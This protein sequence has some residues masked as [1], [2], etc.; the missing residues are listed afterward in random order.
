MKV[1]TFDASSVPARPRAVQPESRRPVSGEGVAKLAHRKYLVESQKRALHATIHGS[2]A[3]LKAIADELGMEYSSLANFALASRTDQLPFTQLPMVLEAAD[4]LTLLR[5]YA[6]LQGCEVFRL[7]RTGAAGDA[8]Q[9]SVTV[10]EFAELLEAAGTATEDDVVTP[11]EFAAIEREGQEAVRAV[12][13]LVAHY[14]ARVRRP[15]L[16]GV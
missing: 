14:R 12:L 15:L 13:E 4:N 9:T 10:R 16:E 2:T 6:Y 7:P 8:R 5:F 11:E 1:R 3:P